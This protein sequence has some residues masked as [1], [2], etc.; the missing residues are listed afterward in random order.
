[1]RRLFKS[2][3]KRK[4]KQ[5]NFS[6]L[7]KVKRFPSRVRQAR[8][9][10]GSHQLFAASSFLL[11]LSPT[12]TWESPE[13]QHLRNGCVEQT[14]RPGGAAEEQTA[15]SLVWRLKTGWQKLSSLSQTHEEPAGWFTGPS[16]QP[17]Q[18]PGLRA[19]TGKPRAW[20]KELLEQKQTGDQLLTVDRLN[21]ANLDSVWWR[22]WSRCTGHPLS[23]SPPPSALLSSADSP[24]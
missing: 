6:R 16:E 24:N 18:G 12:H 9:G 13:V 20:N 11:L 17:L 2:G 1:M 22:L 10:S 19:Q 15:N 3:K 23:L 5:T 21:W 14:S 7:F 8:T 4:T